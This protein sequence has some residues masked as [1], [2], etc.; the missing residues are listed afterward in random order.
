MSEETSEQTQPWTDCVAHPMAFDSDCEY[1]DAELT[2]K[3]A[4]LAGINKD[5]QVLDQKLAALTGTPFL[6][7]A[8]AVPHVKIDTLVQMILND[9]RFRMAYELNVMNR[10]REIMQETET[11]LMR[12]RLLQGVN[13]QIMPNKR[14]TPPKR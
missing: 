7:V 8:P 3:Q 10:L 14:F 4:V 9:P 2:A 6:A 11:H 12:Q 1:C 13:G 5:C